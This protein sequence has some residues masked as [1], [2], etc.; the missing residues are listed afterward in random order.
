[1]SI[2]QL[3]NED[4]INV[5][6]L[7]YSD[8]LASMNFIG[9]PV[10]CLDLDYKIIAI[11]DLAAQVFNNIPEKMSGNDFRDLCSKYQLDFPIFSQKND[12]LSGLVIQD[13]SQW[14][15]DSENSGC[16]LKWSITRHLDK[17][18]E[19]SGFIII[20]TKGFQRVIQQLQMNDLCTGQDVVKVLLIEDDQ[21]C[22]N[23]AKS[24]FED[25][26]CSVTLASTA[27]QALDLLDDNYDVIFM[28]IG[29]PDKD[30]I[31]LSQEL[32]KRL[33]INVPIIATTA[34]AW[35]VNSYQ[36]VGIDDYIKKPLTY[37]KLRRILNRYL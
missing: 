25:L 11:N 7:D 22:Q 8:V 3:S 2:E 33:H 23:V 27:Q 15:A 30:G 14:I 10:V 16:E 1:M 31:A 32:R 37:A 20:I 35:D 28:D 19:P 21:I 24:I 36:E 34:Y 6:K 18:D 17:N 4:L 9:L 12:I 13:F 29:L 26:Y 5:E